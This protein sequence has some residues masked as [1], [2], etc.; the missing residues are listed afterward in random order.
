MTEKDPDTIG[1]LAL[2]GKTTGKKIVPVV[3]DLDD[4]RHLH[5][6]VFPFKV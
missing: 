4:L 6:L 1:H 3:L 5:Q 2:P